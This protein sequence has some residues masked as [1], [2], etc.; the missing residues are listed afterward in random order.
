MGRVQDPRCPFFPHQ[1]VEVDGLVQR[2]TIIHYIP[3]TDT[4]E[5]RTDVPSAGWVNLT[6]LRDR[7]L[8]TA[9]QD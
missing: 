2:L 4:I 9:S 6:P 3:A 5:A 7:V 8:D 1:W